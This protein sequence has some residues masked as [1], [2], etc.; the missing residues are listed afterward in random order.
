MDTMVSDTLQDLDRKASAMDADPA[1]VSQREHFLHPIRDG[2]PVVYLCGNSL[3]LQPKAAADRVAEELQD[4]HTLA[5][6]GHFAA[7]RPWFSYHRLLTEPLARLVGALPHEV[8]AMNTLTVNLHLMMTSF[9]RPQGVRT[10]IVMAGNDFPSD[11]YAIESQIRLHGLDPATTMVELQPQPGSATLGTQDIVDR[12]TA[13]GDTV[14]LVLFSGVHYFT[15]QFFDCRS[16]VAAGHA[17]GAMVGFDLAHA[18][19][20]VPLD[21]HDW[22]ADFAVWCS[23]K[24]L[25]SGPGGVGGAFVHERYANRPDLLRLAGWW[26]ND[27][28]TRFAMEHRFSPTVGADGWQLSNA[29]V[30]PMAVQLASLELFDRVGMVQVTTRRRYL[31]D[32]LDAYVDA[33]I[34]D[35]TDIRVLTPRAADERGAQVSIAFDRHG[36]AVF[37]ALAARDIVVDWRT[38]NVIRVTPAPLY[39]TFSDVA[40]FGRTFADIVAE[41]FV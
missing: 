10:K 22:D 1:L 20:N 34:A 12:I 23:Y 28:A 36:R 30:L 29:Q 18:V 16:I 25:N 17:V 40:R 3:G 31:T 7:R 39:T 4:W 14:A 35:R 19:G 9:Y 5:V 27:E 8:V 26:G 33:A 2:R 32:L 13:L 15:G 41:L 37:E 24:Y 6:E 11:R 38:P 21:L